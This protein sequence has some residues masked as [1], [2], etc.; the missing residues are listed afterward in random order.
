MTV[1]SRDGLPAICVLALDL[2]GTL[3]SNAVSQIPRP[4]LFEFLEF[5][6]AV[7]PRIVLFTA[8]SEPRARDVVRSLVEAGDAPAWL[9]TGL[10]Y[11]DWR[12]E[13]KDLRWV[14]GAAIEQIVLVDDRE[15][16][17]R[18][19][20]RSQWVPV[21]EFAAPYPDDDR[22]LWHLQ[23]AIRQMLAGTAPRGDER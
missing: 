8:V 18:P 2:E 12:G 13:Y 5:C 9:L 17:V 6:R 22:A 7:F 20:Q 14:G 15:E 23:V 1:D 10:E 4:G 3:V 21:S 19:D 11:V 16:Y